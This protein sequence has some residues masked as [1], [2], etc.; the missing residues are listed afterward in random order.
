METQEASTHIFP[1]INFLFPFYFTLVPSLPVKN[2][3]ITSTNQLPIR[4]IMHLSKLFH[5]TSS[6][7]W[8]FGIRVCALGKKRNTNIV[9][10][11]H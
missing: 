4:N 8:N 7:W 11:A 6:I 2:H 1:Y 10:V 9:K 3:Q 5:S